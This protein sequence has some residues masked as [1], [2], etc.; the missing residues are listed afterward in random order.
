MSVTSV[1]D[2]V[3]K[4]CTTKCVAIVSKPSS[5]KLSFLNAIYTW[6]L[7]FLYYS[8]CVKTNER[9]NS[10]VIS[11]KKNDI[12]IDQPTNLPKVLIRDKFNRLSNFDS[13]P[14][15]TTAN[16]TIVFNLPKRYEQVTTV[17]G[18][19]INIFGIISSVT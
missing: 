4:V 7:V 12:I 5:S 9:R 3:K 17:K 10:R 8:L 2:Y 13:R 19:I 14:F 6:S 1:S 15:G 18:L 16:C 11:Q